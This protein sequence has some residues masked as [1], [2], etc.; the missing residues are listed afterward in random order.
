ML[1][2]IDDAGVF[3]RTPGG[4][5]PFLLLDGHHS[6]LEV[7][8]LDYIFDD[9]HKW[10][11]CI[12]VPYATHYWQVADSSELNGTYKM[13]L[14]KGKEVHFLAKPPGHKGWSMTDIVPLVNYAYPLSFGNI[15]R[16]RKAISD[17]G[18]GPL[19]Y[20]LLQ[21]PDILSTKGKTEAETE[22]E[23]S[24]PSRTETETSTE[25]KTSWSAV[26]SLNTK[27]GYAGELMEGM[28]REAMK[29][30]GR[31][32]KIRQ[33]RRQEAV[34]VDT[35][36][37]L[38][39]MTKVTSGGLA[40]HGMYQIVEEVHGEIITRKEER[41]AGD[42]ETQ[43]KRA[44]REE[45]LDRHRLAARE[46]RMITVRSSMPQGEM[47]RISAQLKKVG[48]SPQKKT[49]KEVEA[50]LKSRELREAKE[51]ESNGNGLNKVDLRVLLEEIQTVGDDDEVA[52]LPKSREELEA[53]LE[54]RRNRNTESQEPS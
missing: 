46:K 34:L 22:A 15:Q 38:K 32:E 7:P 33:K 25:A 12:G 16:G 42:A 30:D 9:K 19:N 49:K 8:F 21:N 28:V 13:A 40:S 14:T 37:K 3:E 17:R 1:K 29:D 41:I 26:A 35:A 54:R 53:E 11:V 48:D 18:W 36:K 10:F 5:V 44:A 27:K 51:R 2:T 52:L 50:Q 45:T 6:R 20:I 4:P 47:L 31:K 24:D 43:E 23:N 39:D